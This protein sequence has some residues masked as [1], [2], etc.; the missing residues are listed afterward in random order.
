[1]HDFLN[2]IIDKIGK[3]HPLHGKKIKKNIASFDKIYFDRANDFFSK[4]ND[5][6]LSVNKEL[7][8]GINSYLKMCADIMYEQINFQ[9]TGKYSYSSYSEV[10]ERVYDN[11][12]I[13]EYYINGLLL[14]QFLWQH[15]YYTFLF[16]LN[17]LQKYKKVN[18]YLEIGA[19]HGLYISEAIKIFGETVS[20]EIID[21][22]ETSIKVSKHFLGNNKIKYILD[23]IY[24]HDALEKY[25][26]ITIGEV[27]EHVE[28]PVNLLR[29]LYDFLND[30]GIVFITIPTNAPTIDHIYLFRNEEEIIKVLNLGGFD[31]IEKHTV[32]SEDVP[33]EKAEKMKLTM[34]YSAFLRKKKIN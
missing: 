14:S 25:D 29:R 7:D 17:S 5:Y 16:F 31:V 9:R 12:E 22:S 21:V 15:H 28:K 1:M 11:K 20:Y 23:D 4:Y 32:Y 24:K 19:G 33:R 34:I 3:I 6:L 26:F 2:I 27:L 10:K 18:R 30:E 13:M 8:F